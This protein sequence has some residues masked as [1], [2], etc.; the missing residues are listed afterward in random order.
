MNS[1]SSQ[2]QDEQKLKKQ[3]E[4][5][6]KLKTE[7]NKKDKEALIIIFFILCF[8][9]NF[10]LVGMEGFSLYFILSKLYSFR[11]N[12]SLIVYASLLRYYTNLGIYHTRKYTVTKINITEAGD[13]IYP[14]G[15][16]Y[17]NSEILKN[18]TE[19]IDK[20]K[21]NLNEDFFS[22]SE[23]L[24]KMI[25]MNIE[26]DKNNEEKLN[27]ISFYNTLLCNNFTFRNVSSSYMVG[28]SE[29]YSHFYYLVVKIENVE[30]D[31]PEVLNFISNA[32]NIAGIALNDIIGV[33]LDEIT[34]KKN[35][36]ITQSY[37]LI[38]VFLVF[39]I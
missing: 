30:Y 32:L 36:H 39:I 20:L 22:G 21:K 7:L 14:S 17:N 25:G 16:Y 3:K 15:F 11:Q 26:L 4:S 9:L 10:I 12:I 34:N 5:C 35:E 37:I 38:S 31:S 1:S 13:N 19:Y 28:I 2:T 6:R 24:E 29:I 23:Y 8:F 33:F 27:K 18:R